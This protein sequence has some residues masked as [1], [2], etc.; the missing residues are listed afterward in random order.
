MKVDNPKFDSCA[1]PDSV[2][3]IE[4][5]FSDDTG[6]ISCDVAKE[7]CNH[8]GADHDRCCPDADTYNE[9]CELSSVVNEKELKP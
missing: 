3:C 2:R 5:P 7:M 9:A 1:P 4:C 6:F 8:W